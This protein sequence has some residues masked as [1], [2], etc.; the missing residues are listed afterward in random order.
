MA[1]V[2]DCYFISQEVRSKEDGD[3]GLGKI[4]GRSP[5]AQQ[6]WKAVSVDSKKA[7]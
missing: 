3:Q 7:R 4:E 5:E 6:V 1:E 2:W